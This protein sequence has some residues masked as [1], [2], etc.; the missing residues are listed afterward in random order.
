M[1]NSVKILVFDFFQFNNWFDVWT[2]GFF[3]NAKT[4]L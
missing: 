1:I 4:F 3:D 2:K